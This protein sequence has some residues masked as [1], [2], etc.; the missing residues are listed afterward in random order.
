MPID[1]AT[2][3][4]AIEP[5]RTILLFGAGSSLPSGAPSVSDLQAHFAKSFDVPVG[6]YSLAEQTGIIEARFRDRVRLI[7]ELR[8]PFVRL[9]PTGA[10]LNL[11][12]YNWKSIFTTNYDEL[13]EECYRRKNR[14]IAVY[15]TNID[16]HVR[17]NPESVQLFKLHGT[18][19]KDEAFGD[20]SR[21]IL[22]QGDYDL[23][24]DYRQDLYT[25][26]KSDLAG[27]QLVII[28]H[29]LADRDVRDIVDRALKLR[30]SSGSATK[31]SLLMYKPDEGRAGLFEARGLEVCFSG[32]D[33]FFGGMVQHI[34]AEP[35]RLALSID[36]LD[37]VPALRT[38]TI[39]VSHSLGLP[40]NVS[41]MYNGWPIYFPDIKAGL[42]FQR[43]VAK[44]VERTLLLE[45][46]KPIAIILGA[47]GVGKTSAAR[48][49]LVALTAVGFAWEH[50][51][52]RPLMADRWRQVAKMLRH[53]GKT[54]VLLID[55]A[56]S[57]L[58]Q[59]NELA[60]FLADDE[61]VAL[62]IIL[63]STNHQ[64]NLPVKS[65]SVHKNS[66]IYNLSIVG[67]AEI[68]RLV[69]LI[70]TSAP[71]RALVANNFAG[72]SR[73]EKRRRLIQKCSADMFVCLK[74]IF[75]SDKL[76]DILL[77]EYADLDVGSQEIYRA[78]AA[79]ESAGVHVHRQLVVRMLG[80]R[81]DA[82]SAVLSKLQDIIH[83][84]AVDERE[85]VYAW[86]G[87]HKVIMDIIA[88]HKY[89]DVR[90][91]I[92]LF[93]EVI[94]VISPTYDIEIR[95]IRDLCN[96]ET[97]LATIMI[98]VANSGAQPDHATACRAA[99]REIRVSAERASLCHSAT[100]T[101][102]IATAVM[103]CCKRVFA[104]PI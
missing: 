28:G 18:L 52:D 66:K 78:V 102:L 39:D 44:D 11:P 60:E 81:A 84:E 62:K 65:S 75:S 26:L 32:L 22:T 43:D 90:K 29:S 33:E 31:I 49:A 20:R 86:H 6:D 7:L 73:V 12:L 104:N 27:A 69:N 41:A 13:I 58:S 95:T 77:R 40:A 67:S 8:K 98:L 48:Q 101:R 42:T 10:L 89:Y 36:P 50:K 34:V 88:N 14:D 83:E 3:T 5:E 72:F 99:N 79:M 30:A 21:I 71:I 1:I 16:F 70:E 19:Q 45:S 85:G 46:G 87:R 56:H 94:N 35:P 38:S 82:V 74:N 17:E 91:R 55:N 96:L 92:D 15:T 68:D 97:G 59:V 25:R 23:T 63:V 57:E 9:R 47:S 37:N 51:S 4:R 93:E 53:D 64:W 103:T 2:L 54:G 80:I 24:E 76:D 100:L 61:N